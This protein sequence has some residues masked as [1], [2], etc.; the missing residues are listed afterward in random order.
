MRALH[1]FTRAGIAQLLARSAHACAP[2][3]RHLVL[4]TCRN[5]VAALLVQHIIPAMR[6]A[7]VTKTGIMKGLIALL[8]RLLRKR[9]AHPPSHSF[10]S[11]ALVNPDSTHYNC[12]FRH[13]ARCLPAIHPLGISLEDCPPHYLVR[14]LLVAEAL[15]IFRSCRDQ[16]LRVFV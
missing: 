16:R 4:P 10:Y 1:L 13:S 14:G 7:T 12:F 8:W 9:F 11:C 3:S 2:T 15:Q 5:T 6:P